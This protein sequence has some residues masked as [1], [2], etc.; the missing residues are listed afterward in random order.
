MIHGVEGLGGVHEED[1]EV[2][3]RVPLHRLVVDFVEVSD[4]VLEGAPRD[5]ALLRPLQ[6]VVKARIASTTA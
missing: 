6:G 1:E 3:P 4:V 2:V 5:E